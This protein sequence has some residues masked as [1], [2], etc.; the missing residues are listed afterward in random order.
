MNIHFDI[1]LKEWQSDAIDMFEAN[2]HNICVVKSPRQRGKS[3][4]ITFYCIKFGVQNKNSKI[5]FLTVSFKQAQK[6]FDEMKA[7]LDGAPFVRKM[8]NGVLF[9]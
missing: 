5:Y 4:L 3:F 6:V 9:I 8:D 7:Y 2:R 1:E